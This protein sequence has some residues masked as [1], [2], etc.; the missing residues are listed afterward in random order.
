MRKSG[1]GYTL[2]SATSIQKFYL[3]IAYCIYLLQ[4]IFI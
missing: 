4:F 2:Q 3:C 1:L